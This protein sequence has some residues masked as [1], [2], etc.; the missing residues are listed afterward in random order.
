M[1]AVTAWADQD[2][3]GAFD[4]AKSLQDPD[5]KSDALVALAKKAQPSNHNALLEEILEHVKPGESYQRAIT[6]LFSTWAAES[7]ENAAQAMRQL[8]PG[9]LLSATASL[10]A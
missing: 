9:R 5:A 10:V 2:F 7:P 6:T 4:F 8:P 1:E 3:R